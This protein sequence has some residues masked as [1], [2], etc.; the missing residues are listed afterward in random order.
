MFD[1][2]SFNILLIF[3]T[4]SQKKEQFKSKLTFIHMYAL[5]FCIYNNVKT[6]KILDSMSDV[7]NL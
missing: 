2:S 6:I 7:H 3:F 4:E 1:F 5:R